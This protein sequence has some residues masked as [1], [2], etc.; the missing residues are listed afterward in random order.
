MKPTKKVVASVAAAGFAA[1]V[2]AA[3]VP[4]LKSWEGTDLVAVR[5]PIGTG[6]P[7]TYCNGLTS[8]DG[9]VKLGQRFTPAQCD[10][11]LAV[12]LPKYLAPL[13]AC[14]KVK[15]PIKVMAALLD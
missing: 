4:F 9:S 3:T 13:Q 11:K 5:D 12:S 6:H 8:T 15:A 14:V 2:I 7:L 10:A 1:S